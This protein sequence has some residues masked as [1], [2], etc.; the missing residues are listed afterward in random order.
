MVA[1]A[2]IL[3][4]RAVQA[5][6]SIIVLGLT[7]YRTSLPLPPRNAAILTRSSRHRILNALLHMVARQRS[8]HALHIRL[9]APRCSLSLDCPNTL[10]PRRTQVRH[11]RRRVSDNAIL[12]RGVCG[13][14]DALG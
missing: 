2:V 5:L 11:R 8:L 7:A 13:C 12:V 9:D 10:P 6:F 1:P 3:G 4:L 14:G